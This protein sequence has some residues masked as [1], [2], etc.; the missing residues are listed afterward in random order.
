[1]KIAEL[2]EQ[3]TVEQVLEKCG[4]IIQGTGWTDWE[5]TICPFHDDTVASAG[6]NRVLGKFVCHGCGVR[7]DIVDLA[8]AYL[9]SPTI[10]DAMRW[11]EEEFL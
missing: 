6:T 8:M 4:G 10:Q 7:G 3:I 1:M 11:L 9:Q 2:K 5:K